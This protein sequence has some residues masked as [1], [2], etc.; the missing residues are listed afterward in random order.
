MLRK[1]SLISTIQL[2]SADIFIPVIGMKCTQIFLHYYRT[3]KN[4]SLINSLREFIKGGF[5]AR[6]PA[7]V[8]SQQL[9]KTGDRLCSDKLRGMRLPMQYNDD[10]SLHH[11]RILFSDFRVFQ[12][13]FA[14]PLLR[15]EHGIDA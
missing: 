12:E 8:H 6:R 4:A 15:T 13:G 3:N 2:L 7:I 10:S 14:V 11:G 9:R 5:A 1:R